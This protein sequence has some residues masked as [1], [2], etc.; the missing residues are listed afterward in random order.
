MQVAQVAQIRKGLA[1]VLDCDFERSLRCEIMR[2]K[3]VIETGPVAMALVRREDKELAN[4]CA[5]EVFE[6]GREIVVA[7]D[8]GVADEAVL[9][10][11][12]LLV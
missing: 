12:R 1:G 8:S 2:D 6:G 10:T 4:A 9:C 11:R 5:G 7:V 3:G